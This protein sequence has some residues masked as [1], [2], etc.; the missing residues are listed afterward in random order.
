[1][2]MFRI[3]LSIVVAALVM[4][5]ASLPGTDAAQ[6][7]QTGGIQKFSVDD[8]KLRA[9][10]VQPPHV[11][12]II[13]NKGREEG[14]IVFR[15]PQVRTAPHLDVDAFGKALHAALKDSVA[16][17][18]MELRK[19]GTTIY[20]FQWN[21]AKTPADGSQGWNPDRHMHIASVS[22]L[23][24]AIAM[25][26]L[27][28]DKKISYDA[29][30]IDYLP[31]YWPKG[32][33]INKISFRNLMT[34]TSGFSTNSSSSDY[35]FMKSKVA[36]GVSAVGAY[37]YENMNFGLCRILISIINGDIPKGFAFPPQ[38]NADQAWGYVTIHAYKQYMQNRVF[39]P[40]AVSNATMDHPANDALAYNFPTSGN[41]WNS[42]DLSTVIGGAGWHMSVNE[43]LNVMG[44]LRR[45]GTI[46]ASQKAQGLLDSAFGID[47]VMNTPAGKLYNKNGAWGDA[48]G[49]TEQ[50]LAYFLPENME[51][52]VLANS[53][54]GAPAQFF[55]NVVTQIYLDHIK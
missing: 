7:L 4:G 50:S 8:A 43:L 49:H 41:G 25:T 16:G 45:K 48:A 29:K 32:P 53:A 36:A 11:M 34:H 3:T 17:Y 5:G 38:F 12:G 54:V 37:D 26:K 13:T 19:N 51:M 22:K 6:S 33:N 47:V 21:W 28:D 55:R 18:V 9:H 39:N 35:A 23:V 40:S 42:G 1:M 2:K 14:H 27:L 10:V 24:T 30:I 31:T 46:M 15:M 20:T 44:T 52:V